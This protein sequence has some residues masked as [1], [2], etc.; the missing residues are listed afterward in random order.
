[1]GKNIPV[2]KARNLASD[3]E[4]TNHILSSS[5]DHAA[6]KIY[7]FGEIDDHTACRLVISLS[8]MDGEDEPIT[9]FLNTPGGQIEAG[10]A[11]YDAIRLCNSHITVVGLGS[12]MSMG[13]IIMQ[14]AD[15]RLM[16]PRARFM[17][18]TGNVNFDG[19][20]DTDK[21]IS[22]GKESDRNRDIFIEILSERSGMSRK[23]VQDM[24]VRETYLSAAEALEAGFIDG[25]LTEQRKNS[26]P[27]EKIGPAKRSRSKKAS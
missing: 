11:I 20:V 13:A 21:L 5:A 27:V 19:E 9:I 15:T 18:H 3:I 10:Y 4:R 26:A 24:V 8:V 23:R 7:L 25:I 12:V 6:R 2:N 17:V 16:A 22:I 14:A 1:M